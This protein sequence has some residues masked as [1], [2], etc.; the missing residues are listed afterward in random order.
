LPVWL[1]GNL[2]ELHFR[3]AAVEIVGLFGFVAGGTVG[4]LA[5]A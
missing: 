4:F 2:Q 1:G 5:L 3:R